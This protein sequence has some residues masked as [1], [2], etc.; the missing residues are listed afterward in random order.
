M[1]QEVLKFMHRKV[2]MAGAKLIQALPILSCVPQR[3][4]G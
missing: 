2:W 3:W 4:F 1:I